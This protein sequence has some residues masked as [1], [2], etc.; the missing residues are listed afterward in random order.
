M[1]G[2]GGVTITPANMLMGP[3]AIW[4]DVPNPTTGTALTIDT[5]SGTPA[6]TTIGATAGPV[7]FVFRPMPVEFKVEQAL[8][9]VDFAVSEEEATMT[10]EIAETTGVTLQKFFQGGTAV[11][12][13]AASAWIYMGGSYTPATRS[14]T[15]IH[16]RRDNATRYSYVHF[17]KAFLADMLT[18]PFSR[19]NPTFWKVRMKALADTSR[20]QNDHLFQLAPNYP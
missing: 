14:I 3:A 7:E 17:Y 5:A 9:P 8:S 16:R 6:G 13:T 2:I 18:L 12:A 20:A 11:N 10:F 15:L 1:P 19:S 4:V